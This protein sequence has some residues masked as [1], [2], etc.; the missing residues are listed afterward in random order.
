VK[1]NLFSRYF[2]LCASIILSSIVVLGVM[3]VAL[4]ASYFRRENLE[5]LEKKA[6][7]AAQMVS[8]NYA[9]NGYQYVDSQAITQ[10]FSIL[11]LAAEADI[12][13][14]DSTGR[15]ILCS[16]ASDCSHKGQVVDR[17]VMA[18]ALTETG[19][20]GVTRLDGIY[21]DPYYVVGVAVTSNGAVLAAVFAAASA[22]GMSMF[23]Q[24]VFRMF[25]MGAV[26]VVAIAFVV[27]YFSTE[28]LVRPLRAM[29][30]A[31]D[32]FA[33][34]D[35][36]ARV[37]VEGD[38]E[39]EQLAMAFN[40]MAA[41]LATQE[42]AGRSFIANVS[43]E[44]KTPMTIIGG[45]ID[46]ILDGTVPPEKYRHYL[47]IVSQEVR[48]LSRMVVSMLNISR[49][50]AGEMQLHPQT[51][52]I[53]EIVCRTVLGFEPAIEE[54]QIEVQGLDADK[55]LVEADP[56]LSHQIVYNLIENAVKFTPRDGT[57]GL[58]YEN[59]GRML[60]VAIRNTGEGIR[61][62]EI[63]QLFDR[64][65]KSDRSRSSDTKGVGLGLHI[66]KSLVH[67]HGGTVG[68]K[69]AVGEYAEFSFTLPISSQRGGQALFRKTEKSK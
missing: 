32:S 19:Y 30:R 26:L 11:S 53:H 58:S 20:R 2:L 9:L 41:S 68:V 60:R 46:G 3:L 43:H 51:V 24:D 15:T 64:F 57:I 49:I 5:T 35:F 50:E 63:P 4:S 29:L 44:L 6:R 16:E 40:N 18:Q 1:K 39:I 21:Q 23:L 22:S 69:S 27:V 42:V 12:F 61:K 36:S 54:K 25:F 17:Q 31:T 45:F 62:E 13:L 59:D 33:R 14:V 65:Y 55:M 48:R 66:V 34:G 52:D 8:F 38:E 7:Q 56:D 10:S 47:D 67:L 37:P 28:A